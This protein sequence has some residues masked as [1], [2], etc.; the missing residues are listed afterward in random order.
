M[1]WK[2]ALQIH[3]QGWDLV[4]LITCINFVLLRLFSSTWDSFLKEFLHDGVV[5]ALLTECLRAKCHPGSVADILK[6]LSKCRTVDEPS[7]DGDISPFAYQKQS[8]FD[9]FNEDFEMNRW[10]I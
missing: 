2:I 6:A 7:D 3:F 1:A 10:K 8:R 4:E 5:S 9:K